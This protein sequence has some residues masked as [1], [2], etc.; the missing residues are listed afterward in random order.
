M[1]WKMKRLSRKPAFVWSRNFYVYHFSA[2]KSRRKKVISSRVTWSFVVYCCSPS[3]PGPQDW[4]RFCRTKRLK[5]ATSL[6]R[7]RGFWTWV[8]LSWWSR[9]MTITTSTGQS[10][11]C[12]QSSHHGWFTPSVS[13]SIG[14]LGSTE[15]RKRWAT[16]AKRWT[17][18]LRP[19]KAFLKTRKNAH[20]R[21]A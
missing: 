5:C 18:H 21:P 7:N 15:L 17:T 11:I 13:D 2:N 4:W 16:S 10:S 19:L 20:S 3:F 1:I 12:C 9:A 6:G 14:T 8:D